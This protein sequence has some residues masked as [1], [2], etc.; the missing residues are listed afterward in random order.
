[1]DS[2]TLSMVF[3]KSVEADKRTGKDDSL[4]SRLSPT[5]TKNRKERGKPGKIYHVRNIIGREN[6][7]TQDLKNIKNVKGCRDGMPKSMQTR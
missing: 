7:I 2:P 6:L 5:R 4:V 3:S 1:M